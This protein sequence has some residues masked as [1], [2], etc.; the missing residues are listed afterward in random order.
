MI[1]AAL[2]P[3]T[4]EGGLHLGSDQAQVAQRRVLEQVIGVGIHV[5]HQHLMAIAADQ[6]TDVGQLQGTGL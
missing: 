3:P 1:K 4:G 6:L 2:R 5:A